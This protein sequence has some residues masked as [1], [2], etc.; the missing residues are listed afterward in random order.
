MYPNIPVSQEFRDALVD[1][2]SK[3]GK[4]L[5]LDAPENINSKA[6]SLLY[7]FGININRTTSQNGQLKAPT[8]WPVIT[9]NSSYSI[10]GAEPFLW[11]GNTTIGAT[12][13]FGKGTVTII[14][15]GSRFADA[16]MGITGDTVPDQELRKVFDLE[17]EILKRIVS[18]KTN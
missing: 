7:P 13:K 12:K 3:G 17:F 10:E 1:Y 15:F 11:A 2:V 5:I 4:V 16:Y 14:S 8:D 6:N 9:I 18:E